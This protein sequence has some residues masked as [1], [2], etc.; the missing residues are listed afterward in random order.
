M[1]RF[2]GPVEQEG[3]HMIYFRIV[4]TAIVTVAIFTGAAN[5]QKTTAKKAP[6]KKTTTVTKPTLPPLDV[7]V[8]REKA[9]NQLSN[10]NDYLNKLGP[11]AQNLETAV[12]DK[13]ANKLKPETAK[14]V[15]AAVQE[16][17]KSLQDLK[18]GL[19]TLE[20]EFRTKPTLQKYLPTLQGITDLAAKSEDLAI[21]GKFVLS[22]DPLR[23]VGQKLTDTLAGMPVSPAP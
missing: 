21:A 8:G 7:R 17:I 12:A 22:K 3:T 5:A 1:I 19:S 14:K 16:L 13:N 2:L 20:S 6:V 11:I 15:D 10:V 4:A 23:Q 9:G 18:F